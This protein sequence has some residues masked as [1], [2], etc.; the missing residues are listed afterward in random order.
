MKTSH[1]IWIKPFGKPWWHAFPQTMNTSSVKAGG[2]AFQY[3]EFSAET[4][5]IR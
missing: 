5:E 3:I 1:R 2:I 4:G